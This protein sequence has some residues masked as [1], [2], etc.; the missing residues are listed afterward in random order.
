MLNNK[1]KELRKEMGLTQENFAKRLGVSRSTVKDLENGNNK[2][3]NLKLLEK[4]CE[5]TGKNISFF[6]DNGA[7]IKI[8]QYEILDD[9]ISMLIKNGLVDKEGKVNEKYKKMLWDVLEQE[10]A[11]K[12]ERQTT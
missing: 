12:I 6:L 10:I 3:G 5:V 2:G 9:T 8:A 1:I 11:L 7:E 4:L